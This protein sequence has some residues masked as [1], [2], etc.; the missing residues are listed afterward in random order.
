MGVTQQIAEFAVNLRYEDLHPHVIKESKK[1]LLD[2]MGCAIGGINTD[3]GNLAINMAKKLPDKV[4]KNVTKAK[5]D[6]LITKVRRRGLKIV[7]TN[8]VFDILHAGHIDYLRKASQLGDFLVISP[9]EG[10]G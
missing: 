3:K 2:T 8:G 7:F 6:K 1:L 5:L 9:M 4:F 10:V